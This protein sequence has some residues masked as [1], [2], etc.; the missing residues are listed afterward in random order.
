MEFLSE[1][2]FWTDLLWGLFH[3]LR[4]VFLVLIPVVI[5]LEILSASKAF[6]WFIDRAHAV[7]RWLG[8]QKESL[9]SLMTGIVFGITLGSGVLI[10]ESKAKK[11]P[12]R[13]TL[14][15]GSFLSICH[16]VFEDT[17]I[18]MAVGASG[19]VMLG[20]RIPAAIIIVLLLSLLLRSRFVTNRKAA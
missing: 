20:T 7:G 13:Q 9:S 14:L 16:A 4:K 11:L 6:G 10:A 12:R 1:A 18:F 2:A 19:L 5:V 15:V 3:L 8:F 17:I